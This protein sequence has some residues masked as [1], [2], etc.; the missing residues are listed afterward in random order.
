MAISKK[1][2]AYEMIR[3]VPLHNPKVEVALVDLVKETDDSELFTGKPHK[4]AATP[5]L[6][7]NGGPLISKTKVFT[8][9]W[10]KDWKTIPS[11]VTLASKLN[12]FFKAIL[13]S[14]LMDQLNEYSKLGKKIGHGSLI[15]TKVITAGAPSSV[16]NDSQIQT[17]LKKWIA[18]GKFTFT[19]ICARE[20]AS[21]PQV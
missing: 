13:V 6:V 11:Y 8:V 12:A 21:M 9:F 14:P 4:L 18:A 20:N 1:H 16:I 7:Y 17:V 2:P 10:G 15:G 3:V 5:K 19:K